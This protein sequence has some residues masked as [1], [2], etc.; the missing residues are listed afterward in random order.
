MLIQDFLTPAQ[1]FYTDTAGGASDKYEVW[2]YHILSLQLLCRMVV[3][4]KRKCDSKLLDFRFEKIFSSTK[5]TRG[6]NG[7]QGDP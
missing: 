7:F 5:E 3:I 1:N 4:M 6:E 2:L